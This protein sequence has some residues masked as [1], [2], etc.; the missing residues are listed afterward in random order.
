MTSS[1]KRQVPTGA[2][3]D[4][5]DED[6]DDLSLLKQADEDRASAWWLALAPLLWRWLLTAQGTARL[7]VTLPMLRPPA[8]RFAWDAIVGGYRD[9]RNRL[10]AWRRVREGLDKTLG[11]VQGHMRTLAGQLRG[12][13]ISLAQWQTAMAQEI[14]SLHL[15]SAAAAKGGWAEMGP[16]DWGRVEQRIRVQYDY[17]RNFAKQIEDGTQ[18]LDGTLARRAQMYGEAGR[19]TY[20]AVMDM[21]MRVRGYDEESN[22]LHPADHCSQCLDETARGWVAIGTLTPIGQRICLT[23]CKCSLAYR[24]SATGETIGG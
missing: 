9:A 12:G 6:L 23:K 18:K 1:R 11:R 2:A 7:D 17:L 15:A 14:K 21:E 10:V 5:S 22:A 8:G 20:S 24:K 3:L 16:S 19:G 4:W 13:E